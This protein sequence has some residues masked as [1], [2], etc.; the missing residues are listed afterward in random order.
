MVAFRGSRTHSNCESILRLAPNIR[1]I[2]YMWQ[3]SCCLNMMIG[4]QIGQNTTAARLTACHVGGIQPRP[5]LGPLKRR[6]S[7]CCESFL[8]R[9]GLRL[10]SSIGHLSLRWGGYPFEVTLS[11]QQGHIHLTT[12]PKIF[13]RPLAL[14]AYGLLNASGA[15]L[16]PVSD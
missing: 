16:F 4:V 8:T 2:H 15:V 5:R 14:F 13:S 10:V 7:C 6:G 12:P 1:N 11:I 3:S 9:L